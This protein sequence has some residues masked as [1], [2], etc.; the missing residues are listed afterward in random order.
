MQ[1]PAAERIEQN[2]WATISVNAITVKIATST[3]KIFEEREA[4]ENDQSSSDLQMYCAPVVHAETSLIKSS[5][6]SHKADIYSIGV[7]SYE[8][9]Y[10]RPKAN[11]QGEKYIYVQYAY[12]FKRLKITLTFSLIFKVHLC[13]DC[14]DNKFTM[15]FSTF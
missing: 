8:L 9:V 12:M 5:C 15:L 11:C 14:S 2:N 7:I 10:G 4:D 6:F 3:S 13:T 1:L